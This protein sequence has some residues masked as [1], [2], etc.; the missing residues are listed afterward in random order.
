MHANIG[1]TQEQS[2]G[3]HTILRRVLADA[4]VLYTK[5][6]N[7]HWNVTGMHFQTL[8]DMFEKQYTALETVIDDTAERIRAIG[9]YAIGTLEE[10]SEFTTLT[11]QPGVYPDAITM[12]QNLVSDYEQIIRQLRADVD[13]CVEQYNDQ[14]TADFLTGLMEQNEKTAWMLRAMA[15]EV[16]A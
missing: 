13:A 14:G 2:D 6:R 7:Y 10:F 3:V 1:L 11:E 4:Y 12:E 16:A 9:P 5:T 8:H 15:T